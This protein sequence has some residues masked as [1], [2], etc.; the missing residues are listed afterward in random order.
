V[1]LNTVLFVCK[2][3]PNRQLPKK[4]LIF[5]YE[6]KFIVSAIFISDLSQILRFARNIRKECSNKT[7]FFLYANYSIGAR[8]GNINPE[9]SHSQNKEM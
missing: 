4:G 9:I 6:M 7:D 2:K 1:Y 8:T 5:L 3:Y